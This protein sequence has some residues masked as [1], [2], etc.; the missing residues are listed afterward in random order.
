MAF[1]EDADYNFHL[2]GPLAAHLFS[3]HFANSVEGISIPLQ[4]TSE[5]QMTIGKYRVVDTMKL[6]V[7]GQKPSFPM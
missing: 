6:I 2:A 4:N 3:S 7:Y 5:A 1:K